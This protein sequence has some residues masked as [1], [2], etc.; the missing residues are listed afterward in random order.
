MKRRIGLLAWIIPSVVVLFACS[1][2]QVSEIKDTVGAAVTAANAEATTANAGATSA[3]AKTEIYRDDFSDSTSGWD[4]L[5]DDFGTT[6]Y[7]NGK[8][9]ITI[10]DSNSYMFA[11]PSTFADTADVRIEVDILKSDD[12]PHD[13]GIICRYQDP[14]NFYYLLVSS[15]GW[16]TIGKFIDGTEEFIGTTEM[17][18]DKGGVIHLDTA[19]N[20]LRADCVGDTLTLYANGTKLFQVQD[21]DFAKGNVGLIAGAYEDTPITVFFDNFIVTKP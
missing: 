12:V 1:F 19:D 16:F 15:D 18:E 9:E 17:R 6:D 2:S 20:H 10:P 4:S 13:M 14:D 7:S 8:Y 3:S 11:T 21:T 5:T